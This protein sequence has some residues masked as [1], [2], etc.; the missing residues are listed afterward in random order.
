MPTQKWPQP[1]FFR[2]AR[3]A[4]F[5][6]LP[7]FTVDPR[8]TPGK[9]AVSLRL[10]STPRD[11]VNSWH[12]GQI[13]FGAA[14]ALVGRRGRCRPSP[15]EPKSTPKGARPKKKCGPCATKAGSCGAGEPNWMLCRLTFAKG[16]ASF[17][18]CAGRVMVRS[19]RRVRAAAL[20]QAFAV[21]IATRP[22]SGRRLCRL[23]PPSA[24]A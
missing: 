24:G 11:D 10:R 14:G 18:S 5:G 6:L 2:R 23:R 21:G 1:R 3:R 9:S 16:L 12:G 13:G 19:L 22:S 8:P 7:S 17:V 4:P 15:G 20:P